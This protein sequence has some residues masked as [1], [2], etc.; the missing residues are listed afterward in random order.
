MSEKSLLEIK[1]MS[2]NPLLEIK[3]LRKL[4]PIGKQWIGRPKAYVHAVDNI[5]FKV[6]KGETLGVVGESGCGKTTLGRCIIRLEEPTQ[7][8]VFLSGQNFTALNNHELKHARR[9][10]QMV[11]QDPFSSIDPRQTV[12]NII[13]EGFAIQKKLNRKQQAE[14]IE[15]LME[16]VGLRPEQGNRYPHE[17]SGGQRQRICVARALAL[18]PKIVI[19]DEPVSALDVSIQA[20]ILNLFIDL[21]KEFNL[22]YIFI[23]HD[24]SVVKHISDRVA[25]LYL[26]QMV[27]LA[28]SKDLFKSP[29][30]PYTQALISAIPV[31]NPQREKTRQPL[32]GDVPSPITPPSGCRF[33][34][35]CFN[36]KEIC[37]REVPV[38]KQLQNKHWVSCHFPINIMHR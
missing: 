21:Q 37:Q 13:G 10:M 9:N 35:R 2:E 30:H 26:G 23:S 15:N 7:G 5:S 16:T 4:F 24:L 28:S 17:F 19:A 34:P 3:N 36:A 27:E 20:Q 12:R 31:A 14:Q 29:H 25:V 38:F 11:F 32:L 8:E 6:E 22:T 18:K 33:H 1:T